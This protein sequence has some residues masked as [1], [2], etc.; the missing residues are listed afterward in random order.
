VKLLRVLQEQEFERVGGAETM[1]VNVRVIAATNRN[2]EEDVQNGSFRPDLFYRLNIFPI[3]IPAL[4]ERAD[5]IP[6]L[7]NYLISQ[8]ARR[9]G[10][11]IQSINQQALEKLLRY[12]WPG[13]VRELANIL[14]RAVILCQGRVLQDEHIGELSKISRMA[15]SFMALEEAERRH[16]LQALEKTGGVLAGPKGAAQLLGINRS[17]LWSRMRKLGINLPK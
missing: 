4:R 2:L 14:E 1:K 12:D 8:F 5:D 11:R 17:T 7:A 15:E 6:L 13:N 10:K 9:L 3:Q 16:I